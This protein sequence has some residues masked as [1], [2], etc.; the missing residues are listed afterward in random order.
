MLVF[1]DY[2]RNTCAYE[3]QISSLIELFSAF[4]GEGSAVD[5]CR[6]VWNEKKQDYLMEDARGPSTGTRMVEVLRPN[7][8]LD[9]ARRHDS[10]G[11]KRGEEKG[12]QLRPL[13]ALGLQD[14]IGQDNSKFGGEGR[15]DGKH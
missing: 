14:Y 3:F 1:S 8:A 13:V 10:S 7:P 11:K 4:G 6:F 15:N 5:G 12:T 9:L 2:K